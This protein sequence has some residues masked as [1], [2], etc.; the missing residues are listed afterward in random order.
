MDRTV[1]GGRSPEAY[2][3]HL[4][5]QP[6]VGA[7]IRR[8]D[9][10][11]LRRAVFGPPSTCRCDNWPRVRDGHWSRGCYNEGKGCQLRG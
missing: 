1:T 3:R 2:C 8:R 11:S 4:D 6:T 5:I 7:A 9:G 10:K